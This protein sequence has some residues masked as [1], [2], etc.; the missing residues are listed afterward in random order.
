MATSKKM[1][2]ITFTADFATKKK[3]EDWE[4]DSMLAHSLV[5]KKVAKYKE[6]KVDNLKTK[7]NEKST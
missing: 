7:K 3:G 4:C 2:E 5:T 1:R 6:T